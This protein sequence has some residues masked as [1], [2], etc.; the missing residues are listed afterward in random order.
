MRYSFRVMVRSKTGSVTYRVRS[1][2]FVNE[3]LV[4][5]CRYLNSLQEREMS[6]QPDLILQLAH[7]IAADYRAEGYRDVE[8]RADAFVALNGRPI[9]RLIDPDANLAAIEDGITP[10]TYILPAPATMPLR[11]HARVEAGGDR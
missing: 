1:P 7:R 10:A 9:A 8:V 3:Q 5:P 4:E 2:D 11:T 6:G